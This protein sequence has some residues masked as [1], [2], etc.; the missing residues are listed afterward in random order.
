MNF[1]LWRD[2]YGIKIPDIGL[3]VLVVLIIILY[4][5]LVEFLQ[6]PD[7]LVSKFYENCHSCDYWAITHLSFFFALGLMYPGHHLRFLT[8]GVIWEGIENSAG[9]IKLGKNKFVNLFGGWG[10]KSTNSEESEWWYGRM[11][12]IVWNTIGYSVGSA[13]MGQ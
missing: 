8:Y 11:G 1:V 5:Q 9:R 10:K 2:I 3:L 7:K 4:G 6:T 12:D 13:L